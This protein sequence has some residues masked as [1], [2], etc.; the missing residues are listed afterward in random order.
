MMNGGIW[1]NSDI[2]R[3]F[4]D[5]FAVWVSFIIVILY[6]NAIL[7]ALGSNNTKCLIPAH[8]TY[9]FFFSVAPCLLLTLAG[10]FVRSAANAA[11]MACFT[12]HKTTR[13]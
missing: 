4:L 5:S 12:Q 9:I 3:W 6:H 13:K 2:N 7:L 10:L 1:R 8:K 11:T